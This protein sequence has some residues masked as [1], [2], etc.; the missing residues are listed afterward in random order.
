MMIEVLAILVVAAAIVWVMT[1][2]FL[3][4]PDHSHFDEPQHDLHRSRAEVSAENDEVLRLINAMQDQLH[5][6]SRR[7]QS[8][9]ASKSL[10]LT[11][12]ALLPSG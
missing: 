4:A 3:T 6:G 10:R 12:M 5:G 8:N 11:P 1:V 9:S 2:V 7:K